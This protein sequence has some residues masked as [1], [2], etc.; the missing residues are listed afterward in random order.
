MSQ[1]GPQTPVEQ[2]SIHDK[3]VFELKMQKALQTALSDRES[4]LED[5]KYHQQF[6][7]DY[8]AEA[9]RLTKAGDLKAAEKHLR[10]GMPVAVTIN[11]TRLSLE[12]AIS[13]ISTLVEEMRLI[14]NS[15]Y[16]KKNAQKR[17]LGAGNMGA[18]SK[19]T[20]SISTR[21][22]DTIAE[23]HYISQEEAAA[24]E[25]LARRLQHIRMMRVLA[26]IE[27]LHQ[28]R[29]QIQDKA[30]QVLQ[31]D[32]VA[33]EE[34]IRA[35]K[36]LDQNIDLQEAEL[37]QLQAFLD[38]H[39]HIVKNNKKKANSAE[40]ATYKYEKS[41]LTGFFDIEVEYGLLK[42]D[43]TLQPLLEAAQAAR[44]RKEAKQRAEAAKVEAEEE[45]A[46][47]VSDWPASRSQPVAAEAGALE[48]AQAG[49]DGIVVSTA[50]AIA[51]FCYHHVRFGKQ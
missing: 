12:D 3:S 50:I 1:F 40:G 13:R 8:M 49:N 18:S 22:P 14:Q 36:R 4:T 31:E 16:A 42:N 45:L 15:E 23:P 30:N 5:L 33:A 25:D 41:L 35:L 29:Q 39:D 7:D 10:L 20:M 6:N 37:K 28:E 26:K 24:E 21:V 43:P 9:D 17:D 44:A 2:E 19:F 48:Q 27:A 34:P 11:G 47:Q 32:E 46:E 51:S 38:L